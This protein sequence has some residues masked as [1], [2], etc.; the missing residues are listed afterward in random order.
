MGIDFVLAN[1]VYAIAELPE[2]PGILLTTNN[3][4][5][6]FEADRQSYR[7]VS[8]WLRHLLLGQ[9]LAE[10]C[11]LTE[12]KHYQPKA[13]YIAAEFRLAVG[14]HPRS[15]N[16]TIRSFESP[17]ALWFAVQQSMSQQSLEDS[18]LTDTPLIE[19]KRTAFDEN[20]QAIEL[21]ENLS[22]TYQPDDIGKLG[23]ILLLEAQEIAKVDLDFQK[24]YYR[25]HLRVVK[26]T[27][28]KIKKSKYLQYAYLLPG[29]ELFWTELGN[30]LPKNL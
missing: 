10:E 9:A 6:I 17:A 24:D 20:I 11:F 23:S 4:R 28:N 21:L 3:E 8:M 19:S 13:E 30:R 5:E 2:H 26:R 22:A 29:G 7:A 15:A 12:M 16:P 1:Y 25:P 27:N 14:V 18:G